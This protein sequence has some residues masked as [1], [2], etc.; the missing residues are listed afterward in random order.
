MS[1]VE[2]IRFVF[3]HRAR[4]TGRFV[5]F[6]AFLTKGLR[7]GSE[8]RP[9]KRDRL[10]VFLP[11][12]RGHSNERLVHFAG[13]FTFGGLRSRRFS[14]EASRF[15]PNDQVEERSTGGV[16][17]FLRQLLPISPTD[18]FRCL[19]D[20]A[21]LASGHRFFLQGQFCRAIRGN[22]RH[23]GSRLSTRRRRFVVRGLCVVHVNGECACL[24]GSF[25]HVCLVLRRRDDSAHFHV[26][27]GCHPVSEDNPPM[28]EGREDV[29]VRDS[30]PQRAPRRF[31]W[32]A[33]DGRGLR[34]H[35]PFARHLCGH[36]VF[37][38]LQL[39]WQRVLFRHVLFGKEV[40][41]L[42][43][44]S[45]QL[46]KRHCRTRGIV[47]TFCR[48]A[49]NLRHGVKDA[50]VCCSWVFF[51]RGLVAFVCVRPEPQCLI[52]QQII[53]LLG[54]MLVPTNVDWVSSV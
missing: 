50:R 33:R 39:R 52:K 38:L 24:L 53:D 5:H 12:H 26:S 27:V 31:Q 2:S 23:L 22:I 15:A 36:L 6:R 30:R 14:F 11:V 40:L 51:L 42:V 43:S 8:R 28:L 18:L 48:L 46:V 19:Q 3:I 32:R 4:S 49:R 45:N 10:C 16:V 7:E 20:E 29:R 54:G 21:G 9:V 17:S 35:F 47:S 1:V 37:R 34:V 41:G 25:S 13:F 44:T